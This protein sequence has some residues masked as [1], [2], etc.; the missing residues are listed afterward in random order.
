MPGGPYRVPLA[1]PTAQERL[2]EAAS[3]F[4]CEV[5]SSC[6]AESVATC[7]SAILFGKNASRSFASSSLATR[8]RSR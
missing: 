8:S 6:S 7:R 3:A 2:S 5:S 1:T 4:N